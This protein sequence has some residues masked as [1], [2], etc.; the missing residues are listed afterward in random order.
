MV[1]NP[2][3]ANNAVGQGWQNVF[4][5]A[6]YRKKRTA[7]R[8]GLPAAVVPH[9]QPLPRNVW[10]VRR[11]TGHTPVQGV[12]LKRIVVWLLPSGEVR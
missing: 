8:G 10:L 9:A 2:P 6:G 7:W 4:S 3:P 1:G 12:D 5:G 11:H